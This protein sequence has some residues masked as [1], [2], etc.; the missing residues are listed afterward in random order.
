MA[1]A[2][3]WI[4]DLPI[5][6]YMP[7]ALQTLKLTKVQFQLYL[8]TDFLFGS[9][10]NIYIYIIYMQKAVSISR[11]EDPYQTGHI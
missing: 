11:F 10:G 7:I 3:R 9:F 2:T 8:G 5:R 1:V 6:H 4:S